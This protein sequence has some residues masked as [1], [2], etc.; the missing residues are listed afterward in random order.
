MLQTQTAPRLPESPP[1]RLRV[2]TREEYGRWLDEG[3]LVIP[4]AVPAEVVREVVADLYAFNGAD[5][6][7][8]ETWTTKDKMGMVEM[9]AQPSLW[10]ART[11]PRLV[12]AFADLWDT[13]RVRLSINRANFNIPLT[14]KFTREDVLHW[15]VHVEHP[16]LNPAIQGVLALSDVGPDD[17]TFICVP[18]SHKP[19]LAWHEGGRQGACPTLA[20]ATAGRPVVKVPMRAGD[21]VVWSQATVHGNGANH[22]KRPRLACYVHMTPS[23]TLRGNDWGLYDESLAHQV[24]V[25]ECWRESGWLPALSKALGCPPKDVEWWARKSCK[26]GVTQ[27]LPGSVSRERFGLLS[28]EELGALVVRVPPPP[29]M[30]D[31]PDGVSGF[32]AQ[33]LQLLNF[34]RSVSRAVTAYTGV[35]IEPEPA[36]ELDERGRRILGALP[37]PVS[38]GGVESGA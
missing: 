23:G 17:G 15:D 13:D 36:A 35:A 29:V 34:C 24:A 3:Y 30:R 27:P 20:E 25:I 22:G 28:R 7:R 26:E 19:I 9:Y 4:G 11:S 37:W 14:E 8:P 12:D 2:L 1:V 18:G 31:G 10:R 21:L 32:P 38:E 5:P 33:A 16:A 6:D